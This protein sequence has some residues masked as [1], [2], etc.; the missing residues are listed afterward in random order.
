MRETITELSSEVS[1][2]KVKIQYLE[3]ENN[4][5]KG[6]KRNTRK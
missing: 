3:Q 5:L 6:S 2:L 1:A 4:Y